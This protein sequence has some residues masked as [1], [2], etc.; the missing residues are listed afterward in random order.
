MHVHTHACMHACAHAHAYAQVHAYKGMCELKECKFWYLCSVI[1]YRCIQ[2]CFVPSLLFGQCTL[3]EM[4]ICLQCNVVL[5][6]QQVNNWNTNQSMTYKEIEM[7][8]RFLL[9][10]QH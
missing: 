7:I 9:F 5:L 1:I 4:F 3:M 10:I 6:S 8:T 2:S